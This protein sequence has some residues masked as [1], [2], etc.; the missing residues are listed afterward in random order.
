MILARRDDGTELDD[1]PARVDVDRVER[2]LSVESY[3]A[4]GRPREVVERSLAGSWSVGAYAPGPGRQMLALTRVV[5]DHATFAYLCDVVVDAEHRGRGLG[6]WL[7]GA[8]VEALRAEGVQR[9]TLATR[10]A[11][12][13]YARLGFTPLRAPDLWMELDERQTRPPAGLRPAPGPGERT[14]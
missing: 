14:G 7:V 2:W 11:H 8:A 3:W 5:T 6:T 9:V 10:D 4:A 13:V 1:D 12:G